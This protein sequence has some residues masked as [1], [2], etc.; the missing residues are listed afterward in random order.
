MATTFLVPANDVLGHLNAAI[1]AASL[2]LTLN[3][4]EGADFPTTYP[5]HITIDDEIMAVS[6][7]TTDVLT[8]TRAKESTT[9]ALHLIGSVVS[10]NITAQAISDINTAVNALEAYSLVTVLSTR[11]DIIYRNATVPARLAKGAA[12][13][14]LVM[15]ANDPA[16]SATLAGLTL[17]APT[18]NGTVTLGST[19]IFDA[20]SGDVIFNTTGSLKGL[21]IRGSNSF[22]GPNLG[23]WHNHTTPDVN[24]IIGLISYLGYDGN[25][26]PATF[27]YGSIRVIASDVTDT[28]EAGAFEFRLA[29]A[30]AEDNKAMTL[31]GAGLLWLDDGLSLGGTTSALTFRNAATI[32]AASGLTLPAVTL[33]GAIAGG[34]QA[35]TNI[36][37]ITGDPQNVGNDTPAPFYTMY[38]AS[39]SFPMQLSGI[40]D[41]SDVDYY[42]LMGATLSGGTRNSPTFTGGYGAI[43]I[44]QQSDAL[45]TT[46]HLNIGTIPAGSAQSA[47]NILTIS[48][49]ALVTWTG[50]THTGI[51]LSGALDA[52]GQKI[53]YTTSLDSA[54]VANEVSISGYE[55]SAGHRALAISSEEVVVTAAAGASDKYL[56]VR[57]NGATFKLLLHS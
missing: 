1:T 43:F 9:A 42:L 49:A 3:S 27:E 24:T 30:G 12:N 19:P 8:F 46:H 14:V 41:A 40:Y 31:S 47:T 13:T 35:I 33:G 39:E 7:N 25:A 6:D 16:W 55:I 29:T 20:G 18:L 11:G 17:T 38:S 56:P 21:D 26:S 50:A 54:A 10:L 52:A 37:A 2:T 22:H 34:T 45:G 48:S 23:L 15:G 5:F 32:V 36:G 51:V 28:T 53:K 4:G 44:R 57:I